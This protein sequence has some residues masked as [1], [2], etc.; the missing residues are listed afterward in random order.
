MQRTRRATVVATATVVASAL[1]TFPVLAASVERSA[2]P[3]RISTAVAA[4]RD[5]RT[6]A[7][8]ALI[9]TAATFPDALA[10]TPLAAGLDAPL[11]LT[12][13]D[14]LPRIVAD[15]LERLDVERVW[16]LGGSAV[17]SEA[18][19]ERLA[20]A[21]YEVERVAGEDRYATAARIAL[22]SG[23]SPTGEAVVALGGHPDPQRAWP[24][25]VAAGAL[26]ASPDRLPTLLTAHDRLPEA[27]VDALEELDVENVILVGGDAAIAPGVEER[28]GD[29]GYDVQR[30][31][32]ASRYDTS[33]ALAREALE[34]VDASERRVVFATG[35]DFPDALAAGAL[36][37]NVEGPLVLVPPTELAPAVDAFLRDH[38]ERWAGGI[39]VGGPAAA[40]DLVLKQLQAAIEDAP[41]PERVVDVFEGE[42]SW[43]GEAFHGRPTASGELYDQ[44]ALTAAHRSLPFGTRLRVTNAAGGQQVT[45]RVN[46]RG[47]FSS[48]RVLDLSKAAAA[49]LGMLSSGTAWVRV[50][51]LAD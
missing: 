42:A 43:Y 7:T 48:S 14:R 11:L 25:A 12:R 45:V 5:H 6:S 28:L 37:G 26:G 51:V 33:V 15:E 36:A 41:P 49:E 8:D 22:A 35:A 17:I 31:A 30:V 46:D 3:E 16:L 29:L 50:E 34:R 9:A 10:A 19:A 39:V 47:P 4:S 38:T 27:T 23:P 21:G 2:G 24:D 44:N 1:L 32:G 13:S 40:S 18:V 20:D